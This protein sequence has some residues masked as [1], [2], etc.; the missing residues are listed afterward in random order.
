MVCGSTCVCPVEWEPDGPERWRIQL[1]CG[2]CDVWRSVSVT[3][4][5][6]KEFDRVL[7]RQ[8][9]AIERVL[10]E[11]D[12]ERMRGEVEAFLLALDRDLID[13]ADFARP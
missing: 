11:I 13:P 6:A 9:A 10:A 7:D 4:V 5:E 1:H 2:E 3:N 8:T 12:C